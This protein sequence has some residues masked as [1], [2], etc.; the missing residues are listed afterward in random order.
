MTP[1]LLLVDDEEEILATLRAILSARG[2]SVECETNVEAAIAR[3]A[4][5]S[6]PTIGV[7]VSDILMPGRTGVSLLSDVRTKHPDIEVIL[8]S[9][10]PTLETAA[11]AVRLDAF[12]YLT[13]P[14]S[15][16]RLAEVVGRA[17][18]KRASRLA[19]SAA[20][21]D[22]DLRIEQLAIAYEQRTKELRGSSER[23]RQL[24][25]GLDVLLFELS[26]ASRRMTYVG[27]AL[28]ERVGLRG[29]PS[30][31]D[32][33]ALVTGP[34]RE[35]VS[36]V[37]QDLDASTWMLVR[38]LEIPIRAVDGAAL[39]V[40][41]APSSPTSDSADLLPGVL[42]DVTELK[43]SQ[44]DRAAL[45]AELARDREARSRDLLT[46]L[47]LPDD[48]PAVSRQSTRKPIDELELG[49]SPA[50]ADVKRLVDVA[51]EHDEPTLV[52]GETGTGKGVL[53]EWIHHH[54][55]RKGK[56]FVSLNCAS[57]RSDL[58]ASE[59]FGHTKGAFTS[60]VRDHRG[61]VEEA[62]GGT[63][64]LD[65][66]G[67][68]ALDV[69]GQLLKVLE[70]K[71]FR[72]MGETRVRRSEFRLICATHRDLS[73]AVAEGRFRADL[74]YRIHVLPI[75]LPP[76]RERI[77]D[78]PALCRRLLDGVG[79][80][81]TILPKETLDH[82]ARHAWPGNV[83]ELRN[84][85]IRATLLA[86]GRPLGPEHFV[87]L[88]PQGSQTSGFPSRT[89][90]APAEAPA[91]TPPDDADEKAKI[92]RLIER[93]DGNRAKVARELGIARSSLYRK[94]DQYGIDR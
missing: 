46:K 17:L 4:D 8:M 92:L 27:G 56:P 34:D 60:A 9:G 69:Q 23:F 26:V 5:D 74:L 32:L 20:S 54:S 35:R 16:S 40:R 91:S 1:S 75:T 41:I 25:E 45:E 12:D 53:A 18:Q 68:L 49:D 85:L 15:G 88:G 67:E 33:L 82:L 3:L 43:Q 2:F 89:G 31:D 36:T 48:E 64:F 73:L 65:E 72:R 55:T 66:V 81:K 61:L 57:L 51:C 7:V 29:T 59:L 63:L 71:T 76:L 39:W 21:D 58:V 14:V 24:V 77:A 10:A 83:R 37:L 94:L 22:A 52:L 11:A 13:K 79:A 30:L 86:N 38:G 90:S 47:E 93:F 62:E 78:L 19:Q 6:A 84:A 50:I 70:E 87:G 44:L 42:L 80:G 28:S